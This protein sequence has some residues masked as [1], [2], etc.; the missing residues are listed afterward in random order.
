VQPDPLSLHQRLEDYYKKAFTGQW[1][2]YAINGTFS[3]LAGMLAVALLVLLDSN[4]F[5]Y[6]GGILVTRGALALVL[7]LS[8][9]RPRGFATSILL[10]LLY[11]SAGICLILNIYTESSG[12]ILLF[13]LY[14]IATGVATI[15]FAASYRRRYSGHWEWLV[16]SGVLNLDL[17]LICLSRLPEDFIWSLTI[18]LGLDLTAH[19]SA[20][21]AVALTSA[22]RAGA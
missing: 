12:L 16:I 8:T 17:A 13:S 15:L 6:A 21:L 1:Q 11:L 4:I 9:P 5:L 18:F 22:R 20:L 19:G 10:N 2:P 14:F 3:I 7:T